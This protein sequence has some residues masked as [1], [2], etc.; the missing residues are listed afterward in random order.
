MGTLGEFNP[1]VFNCNV[2]SSGMRIPRSE[3]KHLLPDELESLIDGTRRGRYPLRDWLLVSMAHYHGLRVSELTGLLVQDLDMKR[4]YVYVRRVKGSISSTHPMRADVQ[5]KLKRYLKTRE[6]ASPWVFLSERG[7]SLTTR[8]VN[9]I[10]RR[11]APDIHPHM[12]RHTCGYDMAN[13][14]ID[15]RVIQ[16]W[17]GHSNPQHTTRYTALAPNRFDMALGRDWR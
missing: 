1:D 12:L 11:I 6:S 13:K 8:S 9:K 16:A 2:P 10:L 15:L 7:Q 4:G 3:R 14:G 5:R 17:L